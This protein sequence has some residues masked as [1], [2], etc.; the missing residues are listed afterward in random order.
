[1]KVLKELKMSNYSMH[2]SMYSSKVK[3]WKVMLRLTSWK[4]LG[5]F[6][7]YIMM[8][9]PI[10]SPS[11]LNRRHFEGYTENFQ[12]K[13]SGELLYVIYHCTSLLI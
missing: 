12:V 3:L 1:M 5:L 2:Y 4:L 9:Y 10:R 11:M 13:L 6:N 7:I 8:V